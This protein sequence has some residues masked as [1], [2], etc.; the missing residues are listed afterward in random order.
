MVSLLSVSEAQKK[1]AEHLRQRRLQLGFTQKGLARRAGVC[2]PTLR[3][4]EQ[5]R[6]ISLESFLKISMVLGILES[7]VKS[8]QPDSH[9]FSSMEE[10]LKPLKQKSPVKKGWRL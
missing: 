9:H 8:S 5:K 10:V 3:K 2:L 6:Q 4:F 1:L 7:I